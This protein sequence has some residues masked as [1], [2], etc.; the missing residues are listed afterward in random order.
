M[1]RILLFCNYI[2][3]APMKDD[4]MMVSFDTTSL[5]RNIPII[6]MLSIIKDCVNNDHQFTMKTAIPE[7]KFLDVI[8][9][10]L[11]TFWYTFNSQFCF[12]NWCRC[13][14]RTIIFNHKRNLYAGS[15]TYCNI[16]G[17][18]P[19][20]SLGTICSWYLFHFWMYT[21]GKLFPSHQQSSSKY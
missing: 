13:N 20:K 3:N 14:G 18:T 17:T 7:D 1:L 2:R 10:V 4:K 8:N 9:L 15:W 5:C 21:L 16:F 6:D 12:T 19:S 11:T